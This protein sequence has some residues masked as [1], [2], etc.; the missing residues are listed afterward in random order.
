MRRRDGIGVRG[1]LLAI[2]MGSAAAYGQTAVTEPSFELASVRTSPKARDPYLMG[3]AIHGGK[4]EI[5]MATMADLVAAAYGVHSEKVLEGPSWLELDLF[6]IVAKAP[7]RTEAADLRPLLRALL[8]ERFHLRARQDSRLLPGFA[9]K[10]VRRSALKEAAGAGAGESGCKLTAIGFGDRGAAPSPTPVQPE[11]SYACRNMTMAAFIG[12]LG[13]IPLSDRLFGD[14]PVIADQTGLEGAFDFDFKYS[15]PGGP[16]S[17]STAAIV[18]IPEAL[19]RQAG[20]KLEAVKLPVPVIVVDSVDRKPTP[21]TPATVA[22]LQITPMPTEFEVAAIKPT[23]PETQGIRFNVKP[24]GR[25]EITGGTLKFLI[26]EAWGITDDMLVGAPK[27]LDSD[28]YDLVAKAPAQAYFD[29]GRW[30]PQ[31]DENACMIMLRSLLA[32]R[33]KLATHMEERPISAYTLLAGVKPKIRRAD[34]NS[35]TKYKEGPANIDSKDPRNKTPILGRLVTVQNMTLADFAARLQDIAPGYIHAPVL[36]ATG[37][38]GSW[39]FTLSFSTAGQLQNGPN[40][41][42]SLSS[43]GAAADPHGA[44]SLP[45][46]IDKQLGLKLELQKRPVSVL[47]IDHIEQKPTDN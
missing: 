10:V 15:F 26:E 17:S 29:E 24:G 27:G 47:V 28:R 43:A 36:D 23:L 39:D 33:F 21:D 44:I 8:A 20:L 16:G 11:F 4:Y 37:I 9:L 7:A 25:L 13:D 5:R 19:E 22:G 41:E 45:E 40:R 35:R 42:G 34:P 32:E 18:S 31:I 12:T 3:P 14:D 6:D 46:A 38:D 1:C 30:G 2:A